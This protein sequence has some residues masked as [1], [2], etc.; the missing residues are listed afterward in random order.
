MKTKKS[1][2]ITAFKGFNKDLKCRD[3][4]FEIGKTFAHEGE[5]KAC[6]SGFHSCVNPM[7]VLS[8]Y[9]IIDN[10]GEI[11]RFAIVEASGSISKGTDDSKIASAEI[12]IKAELMFPEFINKAVQSVINLCAKKASSGNYVQQASSGYNAQQASSGNYAQQASSG[13]NA[14]QASSGDNA[15]QASSGNYAK[16]ASSGYNAQQASS[17]DNAKQ[18]SSGNN[19]QQASSGNYVQQASSGNNAQ[20]ASSGDNAKQASSG[21]NAK[22]AS[23]GDNCIIVNAGLNGKAKIGPSG[24]IVLS[25]WS[26]SEKR[27]RVSVGYEGEN[28]KKDTWYTLDDEG[29]FVEVTA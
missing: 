23:S 10:S 14:K 21:D 2:S 17:G 6:N 1:K 12:T 7:D 3:F 26:K 19:A 29:N 25:R 16:Q 28:I 22:Q 13:N 5:V 18:A 9:Q 4:Q 15:K 11:N 8:Y 20:Q 24:C 27:Y